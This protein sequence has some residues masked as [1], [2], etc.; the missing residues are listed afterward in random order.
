MTLI[1][2]PRRRLR[3]APICRTAALENAARARLIALGEAES[4]YE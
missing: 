4:D 2:W 1:S 3:C